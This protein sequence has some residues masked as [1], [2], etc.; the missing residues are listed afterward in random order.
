MRMLGISIL[1]DR[2]EQRAQKYIKDGNM[3][4]AEIDLSKFFD[5]DG[6]SRLIDDKAILT[7]IRRYLNPDI[8][9]GGL[10]GS[11]LSLLLSYIMLKGLDREFELDRQEDLTMSDTRT[12]VIFT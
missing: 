9:E 7:L 4:V 3:W 1:L 6:Q 12:T 5:S 8:I 11:P 2:A 10:I